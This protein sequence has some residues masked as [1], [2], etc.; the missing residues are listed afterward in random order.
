MKKQK[1]NDTIFINTLSISDSIQI[2]YIRKVDGIERTYTMKSKETAR[3]ELYQAMTDIFKLLA[4]ETDNFAYETSGTVDKIKLKRNG[5]NEIE[6]YQ[7]SGVLRG[8]DYIYV[9]FVTDKITM[10]TYEK[11]KY[12]VRNAIKEAERFVK[13]ERAQSELPFDADKTEPMHLVGDEEHEAG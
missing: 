10:R 7:L 8:A 5:V 11:L 3:P 1:K 4:S 9:N 13:G 12:A 6:S 2:G